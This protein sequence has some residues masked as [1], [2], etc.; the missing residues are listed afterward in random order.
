MRLF[1]VD[2]GSPLY[3]NASTRYLKADFG[4]GSA[5]GPILRTEVEHLYGLSW[6][7]TAPL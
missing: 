1:E 3:M 2:E 5:P 6:A 4:I 7:P